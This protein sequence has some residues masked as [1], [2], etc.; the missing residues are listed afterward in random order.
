MASTPDR[1]QVK[2]APPATHPK[3]LNMVIFNARVKVHSLVIQLKD[4]IVKVN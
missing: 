3:L 2:P 1:Q 4:K